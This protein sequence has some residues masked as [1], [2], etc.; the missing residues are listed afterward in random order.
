MARY[1]LSPQ[2]LSG[3]SVNTFILIPTE[4]IADQ[5]KTIELP[6]GLFPEFGYNKLMVKLSKAGVGR[7]KDGLITVENKVLGINYDDF[8][9]D[10]C[11]KHFKPVYEYLYCILRDRGIIF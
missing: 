11:N 6:E 10:C 2:P 3:F 7:N 1:L 4:G 8:M 9:T 5:T